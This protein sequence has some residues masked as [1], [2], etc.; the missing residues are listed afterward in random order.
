MP[1]HAISIRRAGPRD[2]DTIRRML[3]G[4]ADAVGDTGQLM[5]SVESLREYG[6][7]DAPLFHVLIAEQGEIALGMCLY[8][9]TY[10]TWRGTP[11]VYVQDLFIDESARGRG[12]GRQLLT[13]TAAEGRVQGADHL[14][15]SVYQD[16]AD[17]QRFYRAIGMRYRDDECIYQADDEVF[18]RLADGG[19]ST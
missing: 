16:N 13:A 12:I 4:L 1:G 14:R 9:Y 5:G 18:A 17:A 2:C 15:L 6:F 11:G 8:F 19:T 3:E 7:G 10:S